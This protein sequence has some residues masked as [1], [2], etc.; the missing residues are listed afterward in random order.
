M[1][2]LPT[3]ERRTPAMPAPIPRRR[4]RLEIRLTADERAL[5]ERAA[6]LHTAGDL[7]RLVTTIAVDAARAIIHEHEITE[8]DATTRAA[9]YAALLE[10]SENPALADLFSQASPEGY[11]F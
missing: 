9:F 4:E 7:S 1:L 2:S 11:D 10:T 8:I 3:D 5:L 6:H